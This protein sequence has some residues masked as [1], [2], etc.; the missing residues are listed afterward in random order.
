MS[1]T[2]QAYPKGFI[3]TEG[4]EGLLKQKANI[5]IFKGKH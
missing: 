3:Y 5:D 1:G 4:I 2:V